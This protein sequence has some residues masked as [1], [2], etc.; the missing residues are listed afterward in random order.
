[1]GTMDA[2][3]NHASRTASVRNVGMKL[4]VVVIPVSDKKS[5]PGCPGASTPP[6]RRSRR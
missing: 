1:M 6:R 5:R 2:R 3:S 4:E